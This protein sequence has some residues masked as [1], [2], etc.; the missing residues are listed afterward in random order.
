MHFNHDISLQQE[1]FEHYSGICKQFQD[2]PKLTEEIQRI[3]H[4][5]SEHIEKITTDNSFEV[6]SNLLRLD[7]QLQILVDFIE[8]E[9]LTDEELISLSK[10]DYKRYYVESFGYS[11]SKP[12]CSLHMLSRGPR[13]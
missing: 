4:E 7:E 1:Y 10:K 11:Y 9:E 12:H 5:M 2:R 3:C 13:T 6:F 8:E